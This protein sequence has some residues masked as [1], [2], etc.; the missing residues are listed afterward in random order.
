[1]QTH[2]IRDWCSRQTPR[3]RLGA[4][5]KKLGIS[6]IHL[7]RLMRGDGNFKLSLFD[8]IERVTGGELNALT[9]IADFQKRRD[10]LAARAAMAAAE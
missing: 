6:R 2:P 7:A 1:M 8:E 5:A 10:L 9:L 4:F 3:V